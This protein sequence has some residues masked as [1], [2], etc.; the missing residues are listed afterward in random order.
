MLRRIKKF[1][2][3]LS[4]KPSRSPVRVTQDAIT[5]GYRLFLDREPENTLVVD[6]KLNRLTNTQD[7]RREFVNSEEFKQNNT[8][9]SSLRVSGLE[10][11]M[12]IENARDLE[13]LFSHIQNVWK[14]LG[15]TEPYWSVLTGEQFRSSNIEWSREEFYGSGLNDV[16]LLFKAFERNDINYTSFR[17]CLEYGCGLGRVTGWLAKRFDNVLGYD[18]SEPHLRLAKQYL[19]ESRIHNVSL[20]YIDKPQTIGN[21]PKVDVVYSIMVLQ[22]NPPP[23]IRLIIHEFLRALNPGGVAFFQVPTYRLNYRF[24][25]QEYLS[26]EAMRQEMEMHVLPQHEIFRIL[27]EEHCQLV[28]VI[29]D[30]YTGLKQGERSNLF[31]IQKAA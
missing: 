30:G 5:W 24:S 25:L 2:T 20:H 15:E 23:I 16:N 12:F 1:S 26:D 9:L 22:H 17:T 28:E 6:E 8:G 14:Q 31:V 11:P 4:G 3:K 13:A 19:D 27:R 18:I 29:E 21:F 7:I 10:P